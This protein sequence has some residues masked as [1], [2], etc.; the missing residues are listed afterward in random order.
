MTINNSVTVTGVG[1]YAN[2]TQESYFLRSSPSYNPDIDT[3]L[4]KHSTLTHVFTNTE[5]AEIEV[6][7]I[8]LFPSPSTITA[9]A[10]AT[11]NVLVSNTLVVSVN[12]VNTIVLGTRVITGNIAN[13]AGVTVSRIF[14]ANNRILIQGLVQDA[15]ISAGE[16]LYFWPRTQVGAVRVKAEVIWY[17]HAWTANSRLTTLT[18]QVA[19][20][21]S[22][23]SSGNVAV[24]TAITALGLR[25]LNV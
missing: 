23:T 4:P 9:S 17:D 3:R 1:L 22:A 6:A 20:T 21:P 18:R 12:T 11:S 8:S 13:A 2:D 7:D 15:F 16:T 14:A 19:S 5:T 10:S 24:G 25:N